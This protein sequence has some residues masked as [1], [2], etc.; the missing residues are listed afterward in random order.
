[1]KTWDQLKQN[2]LENIGEAVI[3]TNRQFGF[4]GS[5]KEKA[6]ELLPKAVDHVKKAAESHKAFKL[7]DQALSHYLDSRGGRHLGDMMNDG[8]PEEQI[9]KFLKGHFKEF[10]KAYDP[11]LFEQ[12]LIDV[13]DN[14][15]QESDPHL[16][17]VYAAAQSTEGRF[18]AAKR[19]EA[20]RKAREAYLKKKSGE[21]EKKEEP[22]K[23][24][25]KGT[26]IYHPNTA[27][28]MES[29]RHI[30]KL[31][32]KPLKAN[33]ASSKLKPHLDDE[34]LHSDIAHFAKTA[35]DADMRP[36]VKKRMEALRK[37]RGY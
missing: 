21:P 15:I 7:N 37:Q 17:K 14:V 36:L 19:K 31:M 34:R 6:H 23:E 10:A 5:T 30:R 33:D 18:A 11:A 12:E 26:G 35:P 9:H 1:M 8:V 24:E 32:S 28:R 2:H 27:K 25:P 16:T 13:G 20:D 22:K 29:H 4:L 3:P